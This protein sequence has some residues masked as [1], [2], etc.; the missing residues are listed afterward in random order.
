MVAR[1]VA[2]WSDQ[3]DRQPSPHEVDESQPTQTAARTPGVGAADLHGQPG[4]HTTAAARPERA[5]Q[6]AARTAP[7]AFLLSRTSSFEV[8]VYADRYVLVLDRQKNPWHAEYAKSALADAAYVALVLQMYETTV[9]ANAVLGTRQS[10]GDKI[11]LTGSTGPDAPP[12][13]EPRWMVSIDKSALSV[14]EKAL[15]LSTLTPR[16]EKVESRR[17][18]AVWLIGVFA[19]AAL[20]WGSI[21]GT[22][23]RT[24]SRTPA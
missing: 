4:G 15:N 21:R 19:D 9:V 17:K 14:A 11:R 8:K 12:E 23:T 6:G 3:T 1:S 10:A 7:D 5:P 18:L 13:V 24:R 20:R 16:G 2:W 22:L